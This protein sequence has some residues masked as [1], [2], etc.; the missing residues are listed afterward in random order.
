[1]HG[2]T[3]RIHTTSISR[4]RVYAITATTLAMPLFGRPPRAQYSSDVR[5]QLRISQAFR[6]LGMIWSPNH[7]ESAITVSLFGEFMKRI[8]ANDTWKN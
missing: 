6:D 4:D 8:W 1:M 2:V 7:G 5:T 3:E